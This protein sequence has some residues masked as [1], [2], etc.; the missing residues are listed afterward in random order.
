MEY[1]AD[2]VDDLVGEA[3]SDTG[4]MFTQFLLRIGAADGWSWDNF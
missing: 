2:Q 3:T 4:V 1:R